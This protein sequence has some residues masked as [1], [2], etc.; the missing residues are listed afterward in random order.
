MGIDKIVDQKMRAIKKCT[1]YGDE[2][3]IMSQWRN[4]RLFNEKH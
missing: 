3:G 1:I 2:S 4:D